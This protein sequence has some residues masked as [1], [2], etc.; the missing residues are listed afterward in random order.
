MF[1]IVLYG[2][3]QLEKNFNTH[4]YTVDIKRVEVDE[5]HEIGDGR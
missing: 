4:K 2:L 1:S 5:S 3:P